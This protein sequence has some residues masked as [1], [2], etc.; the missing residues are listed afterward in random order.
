MTLAIDISGNRF[1][2]LIAIDRGH[3]GKRLKWICRCD[4][5]GM[6]FAHIES[7]RGGNTTSCGCAQRDA[8]SKMR[9]SHGQTVGEV[10]GQKRSKEYVTWA[11]MV[12]RCHNPN[13]TDAKHYGER[14]ITVCDAWRK[15]F[16]TFLRDVGM[17]PSKRHTID[18]IDNE[19]GYEP[20]NVRWVTMTVQAN[21]RRSNRMIEFNG[22]R[23][24]LAEWSRVTG[25]SYGTLKQRINRGWALDKA[26]TS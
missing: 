14:G 15:D 19:R 11:C 6:A 22:R 7:L 1:G 17:A 2:R 21:N 25:I 13:A 16:S 9:L 23:M 4:C 8:V 26:L 5:G 12:N 24:T 3:D 10:R 20:G 18:R